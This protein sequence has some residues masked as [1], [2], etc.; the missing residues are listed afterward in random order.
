MPYVTEKIAKITVNPIKLRPKRLVKKDSILMHKNA[1][2]CCY[3]SDQQQ[4]S[5]PATLREL[6][7]HDYNI[8]IIR[9]IY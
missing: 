8:S 2:W 6:N 7:V 1:A 4:L 5:H 3:A 9:V